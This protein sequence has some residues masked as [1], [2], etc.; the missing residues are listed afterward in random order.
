M[1]KLKDIPCIF[2]DE[3]GNTVDVGTLEPAAEICIEPVV[4][5]FERR[6]GKLRFRVALR[7]DE[8]GR[9]FFR[10]LKP[11]I[12]EDLE[13]HLS[14]VTGDLDGRLTVTGGNK[15]LLEH[16]PVRRR[17]RRVAKHLN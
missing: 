2:K 7:K 16:S 3:N 14:D 1:E 17:K 8:A 9:K 13:K 15:C 11:E 5:D 4:F 10:V 12:I 6:N